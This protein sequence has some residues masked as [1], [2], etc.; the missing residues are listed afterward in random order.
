MNKIIVT[1]IFS[2]FFLAACGEK[3]E[4]A[5]NTTKQ[6]KTQQQADA[7]KNLMKFERVPMPTNK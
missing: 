6:A 5:T 3:N 4:A 1:A 7:E 2:A